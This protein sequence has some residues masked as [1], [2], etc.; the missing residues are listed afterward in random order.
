MRPVPREDAAP[1]RFAAVGL[2][3]L[4]VFAEAGALVAAGAELAAWHGE[5]GPLA[6]GFATLHPKARRAA[7]VR[8]ILEDESIALVA[9]A[10]APER[11]ARLGADVMRHGKDFLVDK[12]GAISLAELAE[13]RR[14]QAETGRRWVVFF[15]ERLQSP[16]TLRAVELVRAGAVG[17]VIQTLGLGPHQIGLAPRPDWFW[18]PA[19]SGGILADLASHQVDQFL[20][21]TGAGA[22]EV[23]F[24]QVANRAHPER[25]AFEDFGELALRA[26]R[27]TGYARV[28]WFTPAGLGTWG[29]VR[30]LV[31]GS[32]GTLEVRKN[33]DLAGRPGGDHLFL[34]D[35]AGVRHLDCSALELPFGRA[36][37]DD[38]RHRTETAL[39]Q[40]HAFLATEL[41]LRAQA[42]AS[43][44]GH[45][46]AAAA[47]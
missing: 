35:R 21:L 31:L 18:D 29:D 3:H 9:S 16:S 42:T 33:C 10:A 32:E 44:L 47:P 7:D 6:A 17:E 45:L 28:D 36:L 34:A 27:A 13:L 8:E 46:A 24:A 12:P 40:A 26:E 41:A 14:V 30:L 20:C 23:V 37:L 5:D 19:R 15:S 1:V 11:R 38:V 22:A 39:G 4:H 2:E 25:R 43:R